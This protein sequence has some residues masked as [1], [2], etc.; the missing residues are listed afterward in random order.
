MLL[1]SLC[2]GFCF[3]L[4][5]FSKPSK[6]YFSIIGLF[7]KIDVGNWI[8]SSSSSSYSFFFFH[9]LCRRCIYLK[10]WYQ[11]SFQIDSPSS[12]DLDH[13]VRPIEQCWAAIADQIVW[14]FRTQEKAS[15]AWVWNCN[16]IVI[17]YFKNWVLLTSC[18][19]NR[20]FVW[21]GCHSAFFTQPE[22]P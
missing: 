1:G 21:S 22:L 19:L 11:S 18:I 15:D 12:H 7:R 17:F 2:H 6:F 14:L 20:K 3:L 5:F 10:I 8:G 16:L 9:F 13:Q 4:F